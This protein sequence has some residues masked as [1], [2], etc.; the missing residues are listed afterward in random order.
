MKPEEMKLHELEKSEY[1]QLPVLIE[2]AFR[3]DPP[4]LERILPDELKVRMHAARMR[5]MGNMCMEMAE[6]MQKHVQH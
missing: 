2:W 1:V 5:H 3:M 6:I 4:Y